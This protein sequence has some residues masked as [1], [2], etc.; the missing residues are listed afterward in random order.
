MKKKRANRFVVRFLFC[1]FAPC[2]IVCIAEHQPSGPVI[3]QHIH[4]N[5]M[6]MLS[7]GNCMIANNIV[8]VAQIGK[9]DL[10]A[11]E[12]KSSCW[13]FPPSGATSKRRV[14]YAASPSRKKHKALAAV[15][16]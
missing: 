9:N 6:L 1:T 7:Y 13:Y 14:R 15:S 2:M 4:L 11:N 16:I 5:A 8:S 10:Y 12:A 3:L